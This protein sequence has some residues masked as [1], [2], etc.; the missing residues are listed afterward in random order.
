MFGDFFSPGKSDIKEGYKDYRNYLTRG[1][2][3]AQP[4]FEQ[5]YNQAIEGLDPYTQSGAAGQGMYADLLG[6]NGAEA[7]SAAQNLLMSDP[8]NSGA[9]AMDQNAVA[10]A[11]NARGQGG[12]GAA[13]LAAERVFQ[14][15]YGNILN[16]YAG[17][18]QQGLQAAGMSGQFAAQRGQD[19]G[20]LAFG[21]NQLKGNAAMGYGNAMAQSK[22]AGM[23]N[24][25]GVAGLGTS[26]LGPGGLFGAKG[27]FGK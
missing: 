11:M 10:R 18:G 15:G 4:M 9:L 22:Q 24:L 3:E 1:Y 21:T 26:A 5:G 19:L 7:R 17:L 13:A 27:M 2:N 12:S 20:N 23:N 14:Q 6:I 25:L 8:A 16:R